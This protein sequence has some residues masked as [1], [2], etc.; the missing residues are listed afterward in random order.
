MWRKTVGLDGEIY[1]SMSEA[2]VANWL[3]VNGIEYEPHKRLP[4]PSR[5]ICDFYLPEFDLWVEYDGLMKVR[6]DNKLVRKKAFYNKCG[7]K[8]LIITRDNWQR[9][10]LEHM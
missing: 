1:D 7:L 3:L 8:F 5:S 6:A 2:K 9:D 4:A 10:L